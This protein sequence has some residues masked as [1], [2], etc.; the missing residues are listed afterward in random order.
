MM[1]QEKPWVYLL[2]S[3]DLVFQNFQ[4]FHAIVD[5]EIRKP[6]KCLRIDNGGEYISH[7]F[8]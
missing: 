1:L 6:L 5:R 8:I 3:K 4:Q 2:K 7:E